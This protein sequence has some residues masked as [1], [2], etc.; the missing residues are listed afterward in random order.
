MTGY[1]TSAKLER[2]P[3]DTRWILSVRK[4]GYRLTPGSA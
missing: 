3:A 4:S 1:S 2:D